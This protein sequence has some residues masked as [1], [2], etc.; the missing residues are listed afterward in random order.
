LKK[1]LI[2]FI[3]SFFCLPIFAEDLSGFYQT[4]DK[5]TKLPTSLIA[6][7]LY[8]GKYYGRIVATFNKQGALEETLEHPKTR[9]N[10]LPGKPYYCGIDIL[11]ACAPDGKGHCKGAVFDP[12]EGKKYN[13]RIWK[14]HGN[15][16]LRGEVLVFGRNETLK[17]FPKERFNNQF[18][19]P[20]LRSFIPVPCKIK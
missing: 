18:K 1:Y 12:R 17:P 6:I 3:F 2:F 7:Y 11:W 19:Q 13:A 9:A 20:N 8:E 15:L 5:H 14:E 16:I 10:N 4:I